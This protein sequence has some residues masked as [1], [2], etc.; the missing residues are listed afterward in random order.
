M[1]TLEKVKNILLKN[2]EKITIIQERLLKKYR[3]LLKK[4]KKKILKISFLKFL[5]L[6]LKKLNKNIKI[7]ICNK[8]Y[9]NRV[10]VCKK[11]YI[12]N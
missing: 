1:S 7:N 4:K 6:N 3:K 8:F 9:I 10:L 5:L 2:R 12:A 11:I